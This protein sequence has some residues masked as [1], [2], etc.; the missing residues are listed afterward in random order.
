MTHPTLLT[1]LG[2]PGGT[3]RR[4]LLST[5]PMRNSDTLQ[6]RAGQGECRDTCGPGP[7]SLAPA[8]PRHSRATEGDSDGLQGLLKLPLVRLIVA[9]VMEGWRAETRTRRLTHFWR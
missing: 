2:S 6:G 9:L 8:A 3:D 5:S 4:V 1:W 7:P